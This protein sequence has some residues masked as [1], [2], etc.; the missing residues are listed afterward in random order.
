MYPKS[1]PQAVFV[2]C[3]NVE[4]EGG[5]AVINKRSTRMYAPLL[6]AINM[7]GGGIKF[8]AGGIVPAVPSAY[9]AQSGVQKVSIDYNA[10]AKALAQIPA[11]VV[12]V[13]DINAAQTR[14]SRIVNRATL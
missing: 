6:S 1:N 7:A 11:P 12:T 13:Q 2:P 8:A 5:E 14:V 4:L 10:L 9:T 3:G